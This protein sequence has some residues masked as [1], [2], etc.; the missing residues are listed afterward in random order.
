MNGHWHWCRC[1]SHHLA[2]QQLPHQPLTQKPAAVAQAAWAENM[3][4]CWQY[5]CSREAS[6]T[7]ASCKAIIGYISKS[8]R[9]RTCTHG[10]YDPA[11]AQTA[12]GAV[13][14]PWLLCPVQ[15][16]LTL[17]GCQWRCQWLP[18]LSRSNL[19]HAA[20]MLSAAVESEGAAAHQTNV[21]QPPARSRGVGVRLGLDV[22]MQVAPSFVTPAL[23]DP[24]C[25]TIPCFIGR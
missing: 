9:C 19:A 7:A 12:G 13:P 25:L 22:S 10:R 17:H 4:S 23:S 8:R 2:A 20:R 16:A 11:G 18:T 15:L 14:P 1:Q 3:V 5:R 24:T 6:R 21:A